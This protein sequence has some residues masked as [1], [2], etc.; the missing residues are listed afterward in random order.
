MSHYARE[1]DIASLE[2]EGFDGRRAYGEDHDWG[3]LLRDRETGQVMGLELWRASEHLPSE[4]LEALPEPEGE[5]I[6]IEAVTGES[7]SKPSGGR[8]YR[9]AV[10]G[11]YVSA[12]YGKSHPKTTVKESH[13]KRTAKKSK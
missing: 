7:S 11:R 13:R 1:D 2:L 8:K 10:S 6:L 12:K 3:L 4:L 9:S 5:E